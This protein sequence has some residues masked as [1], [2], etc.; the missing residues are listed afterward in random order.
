MPLLPKACPIAWM[1]RATRTER[2]FPA[3]S[4][5]TVSL[6]EKRYPPAVPRFPVQMNAEHRRNS[7]GPH[8]QTLPLTPHRETH[9][10][11]QLSLGYNPKMNRPA[12]PAA[13][14][15]FQML[16]AAVPVPD[17]PGGNRP[18]TGR[19]YLAYPSGLSLSTC[20]AAEKRPHI[21]LTV[22]TAVSFRAVRGPIVRHWTD[23][24]VP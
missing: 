5:H 18:Q 20:V 19:V 15:C 3:V 1:V 22:K 12:P 14:A 21:F 24:T 23:I 11:E 10:T 4:C 8:C 16:C 17:W 7:A 13:Q 2:S 6:G 9:R